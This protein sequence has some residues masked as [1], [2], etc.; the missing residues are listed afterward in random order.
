MADFFIYGGA[1]TTPGTSLGEQMTQGIGMP[2]REMGAGAPAFRSFLASVVDT[3]ELYVVSESVVEGQDTTTQ[4]PTGLGL[5]NA[6]QVKFGPAQS[7]W[8]FADGSFQ[9]AEPGEYEITYRISLARVGEPMEAWI[10]AYLMLNGVQIG[11]SFL[12]IMD[13]TRQREILHTTF[14][15]TMAAA[16]GL[17][18]HL[19]RDAAHAD[20]GGAAPSV[21]PDG[22]ADVPS[23]VI[24]VRRYRMNLV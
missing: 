21:N 8:L 9:A 17:T 4:N 11:N 1:G 18:L 23:A 5:S 22:L 15:L 13:D 2:L 3:R 20:D 24:E 19:Y 7:P 10:W 14:A 16:D 12:L 6:V